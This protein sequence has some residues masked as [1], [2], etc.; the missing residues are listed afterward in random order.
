MIESLKT[1]VKSLFEA[2]SLGVLPV[3]YVIGVLSSLLPCIYPVIPLTLSVIGAAGAG[4]KLRGFL[5]SLTY[6]IGITV[7]YTTLAIILILGG[8]LSGTVIASSVWPKLLVGVV[9]I[10]LALWMLDVFTLKL[11]GSSL[12]RVQSKLAKGTILGVFAAGLIA[13]L[14]VSSCTGP[15]L[16][17]VLVATAGKKQSLALSIATVVAYSFGTGTLFI[18]L[19]TFYGALSKLPK[20]GPWMEKLKV[21]AALVIIVLGCGFLF[22]AGMTYEANREQPDFVLAVPDSAASGTKASRSRPARPDAAAS[23]VPVGYKVGERM[24]A[25]KLSGYALPGVAVD[26]LLERGAEKD[27]LTILSADLGRIAGAKPMVLVFWASACGQCVAEIPHVNELAKSLGNRAIVLGVSFYVDNLKKS[28]NTAR[29]HGVGY[30]IVLDTDKAASEALKV[31]IV[32]I[33]LLA[34][35]A[36]VIRYRDDSV[37]SNAEKL[38]GL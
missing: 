14:L 38:L 20:P 10:L 23:R 15:I 32:P 34:D 29:K 13:G 11:P 2:G 26:P 7:T 21:V 30:P 8:K 18:V 28:Y 36:G 12:A 25:L 6:V 37:P 24:P 16:A 3:V 5:V 1:T 35:K 17:T 9:F 22:S 4:S 33:V 31:D 27:A 19:G